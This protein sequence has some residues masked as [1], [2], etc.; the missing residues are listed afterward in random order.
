LCQLKINN[1]TKQVFHEYFNQGYTSATAV[2]FHESK[3]TISG[4][5]VEVLANHCLNPTLRTAYYVWQEWKQTNYGSYVEDSMY[6]AITKY[7]ESSDSEIQLRQTGNNSSDFVCAAVTPVMKR[8]H[9]SRGGSS[10]R[11]AGLQPSLKIV[12]QKIP[13]NCQTRLKFGFSYENFTTQSFSVLPTP[14]SL[15]VS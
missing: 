4:E 1:N 11:A 2:R 14:F 3:I 8:V 13:S 9:G 5:N 12:Q 7:A 15:N 10:R 6:S